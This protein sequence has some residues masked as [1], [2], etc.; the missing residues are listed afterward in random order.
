M[1]DKCPAINIHL[2]NYENANVDSIQIGEWQRQGCMEFQSYATA[3]DRGIFCEYPKTTH[4]FCED[5]KIGCRLN[6]KFNNKHFK[7][8]FCWRLIP[9]QERVNCTNDLIFNIN[10]G[11]DRHNYRIGGD[12]IISKDICNTTATKESTKFIDVLPLAAPTTK[13]KP[14]I[15]MI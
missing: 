12:F 9:A 4:S 15:A 10:V 8:I 1:A 13:P 7:Q 11:F 14:K 2:I 5:S 3:Y 6:K